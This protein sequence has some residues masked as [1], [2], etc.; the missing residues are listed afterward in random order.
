MT[1][2]SGD[3]GKGRTM[4]DKEKKKTAHVWSFFRAGGFDQVKLD[5]GADLL[6]LRDLDQKLWVALACPVDGVEFDRRTL[7]LV[8]TDKDGRIRPPELLA[9]L[10]WVG[11]VLAD[12]DLLLDA[13]DEID[14]EDIDGESA[15]G[16]KLLASAKG[17][18]RDLGKKGTKSISIADVA[19]AEKAFA[20]TLLNG[21]GI[22]PPDSAAEEAVKA[23]IADV[24][25]C[26]GGEPDRSGKEGVSKAKLEAF[27]KEAEAFDAWWKKAEGARETI[28]PAGDGT[29]AALDAVRGVRAKVDDW[30]VRC[31]LAAFDARSAAPLNRDEATYAALAAKELTANAKE[32]AE[33]PL[34]KVEA[35]RALPLEQGVNP[36]WAEALRKL[37]TDAVRPLLGDKDALTEADW[38]Q[39]LSKL[40]PYEAWQ[41]EKAG[42]GVE[43]LGLP[44][45]RALLEPAARASIEKLIAE[46]AALEGE[47]QSIA[48]VEKL[49]RFRRDLRKLCD[50]FVSFRDFYGRKEKAI[51]QAG[52]LYIDGRSCDL[53]IKV[54]DPGAHA[55][56][57]S[58]AK[59]HLL[60]CDLTRKGSGEK[61]TI[62]AAMTAGDDIDLMVG[63]N[64]VFYDRKGND[65]DATIVKMV[66]HP[67]SI[68]QAFWL[69]YRRIGRLIGEQIHKFASSRDE[70]MHK[71]AASHVGETA[72]A[73]E[74]GSDATAAPAAPFD[75]GKFAGIFAAI[76]LAI[77]AIGTALAAVVTGFIGLAWWQMP[78]AVAGVILLVSGPSMLI[79]YLKL[80][81]RNLGP[82]LDA[83][84][85]AVNAK[86]MVN[87][88]FGRSL[89][90]MAELPEGAQRSTQDP[91]Q[92]KNTTA[93]TVLI[94]MG[95]VCVL[96][97]WRAGMLPS[98]SSLKTPGLAPAAA[99]SASVAP[100]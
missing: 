5:T 10:E 89:T 55:A 90:K 18:L 72:S 73:A 49:L 17:V 100:K 83:S 79:A 70:A 4:A 82:L 54:G 47:Y 97:L 75:V 94:V 35:G 15:E 37:R 23:A 65:W 63:R 74:R 52:T 24:I 57:A 60:Y 27:V 45:V 36:A 14:L 26:V 84:G 58:L 22:V 85:W 66:E 69:P 44:R 20:G 46:D 3:H 40:A 98:W 16:K 33:L 86:A 77:G 29:A 78:L 1:P 51:F 21:D 7:E 48:S 13:K 6:A 25:A 11:G 95:I 56:L 8:D 87:I 92:H 30:F 99:P 32:I 12:P 31:R 43:K 88:P 53:C 34:A 61:M 76:G 64:G 39:L 19:A 67:I 62:V 59:T 28:L 81:Q 50:N 42:A 41:A 2:D 38:R 68:R 71:T 93:I 80:R 9:A 91:F 96:L